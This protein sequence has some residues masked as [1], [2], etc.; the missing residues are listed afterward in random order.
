MRELS[1]QTEIFNNVAHNTDNDNGRGYSELTLESPAEQARR[2]CTGSGTKQ[3]Q[4]NAC[5]PD[6][7]GVVSSGHLLNGKIFTKRDILTHSIGAVPNQWHGEGN[8]V[9]DNGKVAEKITSL[10]FL[11]LWVIWLG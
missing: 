4:K 3:K 8:K 7:G 5:H 9:W 10:I 2:L 11:V 1:T 6:V